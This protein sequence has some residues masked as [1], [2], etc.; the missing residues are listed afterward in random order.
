M[1]M[2]FDIGSFLRSRRFLPRLGGRRTPVISGLNLQSATRN[3]RLPSDPAYVVRHNGKSPLGLA[4]KLY[5]AVTL[6]GQDAEVALFVEG[7]D[8][9]VSLVIETGGDQGTSGV[10]VTGR[11]TH[12][13][14]R[15]F[16]DFIGSLPQPIASEIVREHS[17][18]PIGVTVCLM[19]RPDAPGGSSVAVDIWGAKEEAA[20]RLDQAVEE[21]PIHKKTVAAGGRT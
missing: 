6:T 9:K 3:F 13:S 10:R 8:R 2:L 11:W 7:S 15:L 21:M 19:C 1:N 17:S 20:L 14:G 18:K 4:E 16:Q 12:Q 5:G